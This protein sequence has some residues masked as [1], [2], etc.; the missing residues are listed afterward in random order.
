L[1]LLKKNVYLLSET[2]YFVECIIAFFISRTGSEA[3]AKATQEA[4]IRRESLIDN[5]EPSML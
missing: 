2:T 1:L 4:G 3:I 5:L